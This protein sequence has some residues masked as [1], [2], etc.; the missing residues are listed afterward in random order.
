M[1]YDFLLNELKLF[2]NIV[3]DFL[4]FF[5]IIRLWGIRIIVIF[6]NKYNYLFLC[7]NIK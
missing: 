1:W 4:F 7:L 3:Y 6:N 2:W 5:G